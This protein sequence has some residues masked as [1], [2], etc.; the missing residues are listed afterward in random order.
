MIPIDYF[1]K[2]LGKKGVVAAS[3][4]MVT[5]IKL[6]STLA[7]Q[8]RTSRDLLAPIYLHSKTLCIRITTVLG[9]STALSL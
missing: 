4:D 5:R 6:R 3:A 9:G 2:F 7:D 8:D 1:A